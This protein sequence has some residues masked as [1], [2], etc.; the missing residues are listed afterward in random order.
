MPTTE[1]EAVIAEAVCGLTHRADGFDPLELLHDLTDHA[2]ALLPVQGAGVTVLDERGEVSYATASDE[3]CREL[4]EIQ[5][6]LD[7]GPCVDSARDG[8]LLA[9]VEL[10][11]GRPGDLRWPRFTRHARA[12]GVIAVAAVPLSAPG[13][14]LGALNLMIARPPLPS[15]L[16]VRLAQVLATAVAGR[17]QLQQRLHSQETV[18][19]QLQG[20]L[21][22]RIVIEQAKGVLSERHR[23]SMDEA[24]ARLRAHARSRRRKLSELAAE[25]AEGQG[26]AELNAQ[27]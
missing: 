2:L 4:E 14:T 25:V 10:G 11:H 18:V 27:R 7:E 19:G 13:Y 21:H 9:P 1:R 12:V 23:I 26:P 17:F 16:D 8:A 22:S 5:V 20:A 24:F 15:P 3:C 6:D